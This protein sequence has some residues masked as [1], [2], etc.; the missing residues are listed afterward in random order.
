[1]PSDRQAR[2]TAAYARWFDRCA[3]GTCAECAAVAA[4]RH[5]LCEW[6][7]EERAVAVEADMH[8]PGGTKMRF[9]LKPEADP[10]SPEA[11]R[12]AYK[13]QLREKRRAAGICVSC[14]RPAVPGLTQCKKH[15]ELNRLNLVR[16]RNE[17]IVK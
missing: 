12:R 10:D 14:A 17:P 15:R 16:T 11:R 6:H 3:L 5:S 9:A 1:M 13:R 4:P 2:V 7:L 8:R